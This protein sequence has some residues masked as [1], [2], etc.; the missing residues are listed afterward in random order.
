MLHLIAESFNFLQVV[1]VVFNWN[2]ESVSLY[3]QSL[4]LNLFVS[5]TAWQAS[6]A[7]PKHS[8]QLVPMVPWTQGTH[9]YA[10]SEFTSPV[11]SVNLGLKEGDL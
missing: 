11:N 10:K 6:A 1:E 2:L 8:S 4:H 5:M 9:L 7:L 3:S